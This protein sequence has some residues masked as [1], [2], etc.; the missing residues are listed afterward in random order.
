[1]E[2][3]VEDG[4]V[5]SL[6]DFLATLHFEDLLLEA[7]RAYQWLTLGNGHEEWEVAGADALES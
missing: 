4:E 3:F 2:D 1:L 5:V 6:G 7:L